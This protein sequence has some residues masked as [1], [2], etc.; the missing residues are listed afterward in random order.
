MA[1]PGPHIATTLQ[2]FLRSLAYSSENFL[3]NACIPWLAARLRSRQGQGDF[4]PGKLSYPLQQ[5]PSSHHSSWLINSFPLLDLY[6]FPV[7][8]T[9]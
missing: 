4:L 8:G 6:T 3:K 9:G 1:K 5:Y 7:R 2:C